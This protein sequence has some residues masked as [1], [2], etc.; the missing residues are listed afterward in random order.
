MLD[1]TTTTPIGDTAPIIDT[2]PNPA[3]PP[4]NMDAAA[5]SADETAATV[6]PWGE[7]G[8]T[9]Y[10]VETAAATAARRAMAGHPTLTASDA[11]TGH[12]SD[13]VLPFH[14][15]SSRF[16]G[17]PAMTGPS[18]YRRAA[19]AMIAI[20]HRHRRAAAVPVAYSS[21]LDPV[22]G[23]PGKDTPWLFKIG[24]VDNVTIGAAERAGATIAWL[25]TVQIGAAGA[26]AIMAGI[27][28][29]VSTWNAAVAAIVRWAGKHGNDRKSDTT[30]VDK[31]IGRAAGVLTT[32]DAATVKAIVK[33]GKT[34]RKA[35]VALHKVGASD[36]AEVQTRTESL[37]AG[38]GKPTKTAGPDLM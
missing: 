3:V 12:V 38:A 8:P 27:G 26:D 28:V 6:K 9:C 35:A 30:V 19:R 10:A 21:D 22:V 20:A 4:V 34:T 18:G 13:G 25:P 7:T 2:D 17:W 29:K 31:M 24:G 32:A 33:R 5:G 11:G 16:K 1:T 36:R 37:D 14:A 23:R 15:A